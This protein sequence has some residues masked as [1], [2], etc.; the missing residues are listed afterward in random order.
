MNEIEE[1]V[2]DIIQ[3][4]GKEEFRT[5]NAIGMPRSQLLDEQWV[6]GSNDR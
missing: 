5:L 1:Y 3:H 6:K 4:P 2:K